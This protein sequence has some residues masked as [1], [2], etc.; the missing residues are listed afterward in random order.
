VETVVFVAAELT[1]SICLKLLM[2][3]EPANRLVLSLFNFKK[4]LTLTN[5]MNENQKK[6]A[7]GKAS[8]TVVKI[9][10][11]PVRKDVKGGRFINV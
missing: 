11:L 1:R 7:V 9:K 2:Q 3:G 5:P 4:S 6:P 8:A 10:E